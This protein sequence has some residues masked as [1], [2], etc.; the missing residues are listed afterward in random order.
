MAEMIETEEMLERNRHK[1]AFMQEL[2]DTQVQEARKHARI[3]A[4]R[5]KRLQERQAQAA[6]LA[7][8]ESE[9]RSLMA[10]EELIVRMIMR[11]KVG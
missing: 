6:A 5:E 10:K 7:A 8:R 9:E 4:M 11:E 3:K 1:E 2:L